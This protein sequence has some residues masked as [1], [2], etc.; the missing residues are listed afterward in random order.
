MTYRPD[1][2]DRSRITK[3]VYARAKGRAHMVVRFAENMAKAITH[4]DKAH[5]RGAA[6][7]E[8]PAAFGP[9]MQARVAAIFMARAAELAGA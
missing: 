9:A 5:R 2:K 6:V 1:A 4:A 8:V 7:L 3:S